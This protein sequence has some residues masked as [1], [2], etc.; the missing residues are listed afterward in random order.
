MK[1]FF[2][3]S[4]S[5]VAILVTVL[6][7][8]WN[9]LDNSNQTSASVRTQNYFSNFSDELGNAWEA[10]NFWDGYDEVQNNLHA[11]ED[12]LVQ[13]IPGDFHHLLMMAFYSKENYPRTF[14]TVHAG[15]SDIT[16]RD[17]GNGDDKIAGDGLFT[18]KISADVNEFRQTVVKMSD[19]MKRA[20]LK[21]LR[22][23][24][25]SMEVNPDATESFNATAFDNNQTVSISNLQTTAP[26]NTIADLESHSIFITDTKVV[27]DPSRTW[28]P[29][30]QTGNLNGAWTFKTLIKNLAST[31]PK[32]L[33][34]DATV[35][36]FVKDWLSKWETNR[37]INGDR[38]NAR[39]LVDD[40]ILNPWLDK[41]AKSGSPTG[42]LNM[43]FAPFK[44]LA[45]L[46]RF[47]LRE[48]F[49][50]IPCGEGRFIFCLLD[51]TCTKAENF[52]VIFEFG[53][54]KPDV[55]D[56]LHA[57]AQQWF[58]LKKFDVG[59]IDYNNALQAITDQFTLCGDD[60]TKPNQNCLD[61]LRTN[62][63]ALSPNPVQCEFRQF[64]LS[65]SDHKLKEVTITDAP[66]DRYNVQVDNPAVERWVT[67]TNQNKRAIIDNHIPVP[68]TFEDSPLLAGKS[69]ILGPTTGDPR[70]VNVYH[71][72]G[73]EP[74]GS[75][76][77]IKSGQA[78]QLNS[79]NACS[80]CH[81][82]ETQTNFTHVDPVFFGKEATLS[83]FLTGKPGQGGAFDADGDP[84]ND[85]MMV[86]DPALRPS[87]DN[88][89]I[90]MFN[91]IKRRATDLKETVNNSC[92]S[93]LQ[94]RNSLMFQPVSQVH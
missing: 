5:F 63:R 30:S 13:K 35:S 19:D 78:R 60:V 69:T 66:Q 77:F 62:D 84:N 88:P 54:P 16:F 34:D 59:S 10:E 76:A 9:Q 29:C 32:H 15:G 91:D 7:L 93:P 18:A 82:G 41:S 86:I 8:S 24:D 87:S 26:G 37:T 3:Y 75:A 40:K 52:T 42:Q 33:A 50:G 47:D 89:N 57:W 17:D 49:T 38:V 90:R 80:G 64:G 48:R 74:K 71:W 61:A 67:W 65:S 45:I 36:D 58:D 14:V 20:G 79:L 39:K 21:P 46:N 4:I 70:K 1:N 31:D 55:C 11:A 73:T 28:N 53:I 81:S 23:R 2:N 43:K 22:F 27:E 68:T 6:L 72:D 12:V 94:I 25:R 51:T 83:G 44:L 85:S 92:G 56:S